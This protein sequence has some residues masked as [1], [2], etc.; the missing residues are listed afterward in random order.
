MRVI[1]PSS[2]IKYFSRE[3]GWDRVRDLMR[4]GVIT[5]DLAVKEVANALWKKVLTSSPL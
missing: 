4:D 1:D 2:L 5:L 3:E